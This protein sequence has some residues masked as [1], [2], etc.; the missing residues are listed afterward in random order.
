MTSRTLLATTALVLM[1]GGTAR[2]AELSTATMVTSGNHLLWC[3]IVNISSVVQTVWIRI[4]DKSGALAVDSGE[5]I[6]PARATA[7]R[8]HVPGLR[9]A[10]SLPGSSADGNGGTDV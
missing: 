5:V 6:L 8:S 3:N 4:Y 2:A 10:L 7:W 9:Q 1:I